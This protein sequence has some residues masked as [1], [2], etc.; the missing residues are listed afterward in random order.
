MTVRRA[1]QRWLLAVFV[2]VLLPAAPGASHAS[3]FTDPVDGEFDV[4]DWLLNKR[5]FLPVAIL[6]TE[7]AVGYGGGAALLFFHRSKQD[8]AEDRDPNEPLGL[9]PS[10]SGVLGA[11]TA[12]GSWLS[13]GFH[14]GSFLEDRIRYTGAVG[15]GQFNLDYFFLGQPIAYELKGVFVHQ[16][17][18]LRIARS[19]VFLGLRYQW[20]GVDTR[21]R[22]NGVPPESGLPQSLETSESGLAVLARYDSRDNIFSPDRGINAEFS[23]AFFSDKLGGDS[24][25]QRLTLDMRGYYPV[26][27]RLVVSGRVLARS[28]LGDAPFY[29][30]P[31]V[32]LR[33]I[34]AQRYQN[35][36]AGSAQLELRWRVWR[37][38]SLVGFL[39]GGWEAGDR[40]PSTDDTLLAG[41]AGFRYLI[42]RRLGMQVGLDY[43]RGPDENVVYIQTGGEF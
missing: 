29:V 39:G 35:Q 19:P 15:G 17:I 42:A 12:N 24:N 25:Y 10:V 41:G 37:R 21:L 31:W 4:S 30:L 20:F 8:R 14:F 34:R 22:T 26:H 2:L 38:F 33:G 23:A 9:P 7:P 28:A 11:G 43:G 18:Q 1:A 32:E 16:D 6:I 5:G 13:G 27:P 40:K 36:H 3:P